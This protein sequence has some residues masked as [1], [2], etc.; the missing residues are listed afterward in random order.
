MCA[1]DGQSWSWVGYLNVATRF[2]NEEEVMR[3]VELN[4]LETTTS[5]YMYNGVEPK[6]LKS[7]NKIRK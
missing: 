3:F 5:L 2:N 6:L 1:N 4:K 7:V